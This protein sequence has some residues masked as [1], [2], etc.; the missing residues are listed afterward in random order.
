MQVYSA[1]YQLTAGPN[2]GGAIRLSGARDRPVGLL[3]V[4]RVLHEDVVVAGPAADVLAVVAAEER[5]VLVLVG[6]GHVVLEASRH[7]VS[8]QIT[9]TWKIWGAD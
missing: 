3:V 4:G 8:A 1:A 7:R 6:N 5:D 9:L 2:C